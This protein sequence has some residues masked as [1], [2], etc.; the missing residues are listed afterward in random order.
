MITYRLSVLLEVK[1]PNFLHRGR[2]AYHKQI[3]EEIKNM[4][5]RMQQDMAQQN[6]NMLEMKEE[7]KNTIVNSLTE[8]FDNIEQKNKLLEKKID[9]QHTRINYLERQLRRRNIV[10]FG[11]EEEEN[12]YH[13][14]EEKIIKIITTYLEVE[15]N[16]NNIEATRRLGKKGEKVRPVVVTLNTMGLKI[17]ILKNKFRLNN[18]TYYIKENYPTEV[19]KIRKELQPQLQKQKEAGNNAIIRYDKLIVLSKQQSPH[20]NYHKRNFSESPETLT[21]TTGQDAPRSSKQP[22]KKNKTG[23]MKN[24]I[25]QQ[26]KLLITPKETPQLQAN[27][28]Q[29]HTA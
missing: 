24:Y 18:T 7:I 10:L 8:R 28:L 21:P 17:K 16:F 1:V 2:Y 6:Q 27:V 12:S 3:M 23:T 29:H 9:D 4:L 25:I 15:C 20:S 14:L 19:L 11:L 13:E 5:V 22:S 26:P